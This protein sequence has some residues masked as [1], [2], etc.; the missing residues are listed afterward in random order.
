M[1]L[2]YPQK[3][4]YRYEAR[5][6]QFGTYRLIDESVRRIEFM[7]FDYPETASGE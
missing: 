4:K 6:S 1:L 3:G 5:S 2:I 7:L